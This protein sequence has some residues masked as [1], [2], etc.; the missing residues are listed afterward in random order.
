[1]RRVS[2][3]AFALVALSALA[4]SQSTSTTPSTVVTGSGKAHFVPIWTGAQE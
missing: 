2:V 3:L 1:M 4:Q